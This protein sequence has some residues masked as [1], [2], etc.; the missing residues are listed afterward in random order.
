MDL[1]FGPDEERFRERVRNFLRENLPPKWG[2][3]EQRLPEGL[4]QVEFL[5]DWQRRLHQGGLLGMSWPKEYGGQGASRTEMAIF[6]EEMALCRAPGPLNALGLSM[7]GPTIITHGTE[8]QK[9]RYLRKILNCEEI[10]CQGFSEP[11]SGSDVASLRTRAELRGDEFIVNGQKVWTSM[12]HLADWCMLL[13][14][15]DPEAP[16]HRGLSYLLVDMRTPGVTVKPLRQM[17]GE[18][19]FNEVFFEDVRVPRANLVTQRGMAGRDDYA[20]ERA[21]DSGV[22]FGGALSDCVRRDRGVGARDA[23]QWR[24]G[25][26]RSGCPSTARA[27]PCRTRDDEVHVVPGVLEDSQGRRPGAGG[28]DLEA[29]L[30]GA[31]PA[32]DRVRGRASR[33]RRAVGQGFAARG[34]LGAL[35]ASFFARARE[36][37]R[38]GDVRDS[39]PHHRRARAGDAAEPLAPRLKR[40]VRA[41]GASDARSERP[42]RTAI[43]TYDRKRVALTTGSGWVLRQEAAGAIIRFPVDA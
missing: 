2:T 26:Q 23:A 8:E 16:K 29:D 19:E 24:A 17:T 11:N 31:E 42:C 36:H 18:S 13:V 28:I 33:S 22:R 5:R 3:A 14:R 30:V 34:A 15:T 39:A 25:D 9:R 43:I 35:A 40:T 4:T 10:W 1:G 7:A 37:D 27:V 6:N 12:A 20:D 38:G 32:D 21:R 41:D